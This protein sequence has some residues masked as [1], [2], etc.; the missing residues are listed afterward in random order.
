MLPKKG[1]ENSFLWLHYSLKS[2]KVLYVTVKAP[3]GK[4]SFKFVMGHDAKWG[5]GYIT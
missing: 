3:K 5:G 2:A 1:F 4:C